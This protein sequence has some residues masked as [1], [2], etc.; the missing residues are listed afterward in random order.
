MAIGIYAFSISDRSATTAP[1]VRVWVLQA[2]IRMVTSR[3]ATSS[4]KI[5]KN[6]S[7]ISVIFTFEETISPFAL[8]AFSSSLG[9]CRAR[10]K[11]AISISPRTRKWFKSSSLSR[12]LSFM[13]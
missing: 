8:P 12:I 3:T 6:A 4:T 2:K 10:R 5:V 7:C 1:T 9:N 13:R 11:V